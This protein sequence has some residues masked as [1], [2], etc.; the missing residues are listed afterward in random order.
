MN[1]QFIR[2]SS[3]LDKWE[4]A[5]KENK[6]V[7]VMMDANLDHLTWGQTN[8]LSASHSSIKLKSLIDLLFEK[9][10]PLGFSQMVKCATRFERGQPMSG[11][12]HLYTNKPEKL[13]S[14]QTYFTGL[15]DHKLLKVTRFS[16]SFRQLPR[17]VRKRMFKNFNKDEFMKMLGESRFEDILY[18]YDVDYAANMLTSKIT[19]ILDILAPVKTIQVKSY[20]VPGLSQETKDLQRERNFA[21]KM[22]TL[23][24]HPYDW[25]HFRSLRNR[26]TASLR[27]DKV[28]CD[29]Y[30][31]GI[32]LSHYQK[33]QNVTKCYHRATG[34]LRSYR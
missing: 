21:Q 7:I 10:I 4:F 14:V 22:A 31:S 6:E 12:D 20:Y 15:S 17:Y 26:A 25:R 11:L 32:K 23:T 9:I 30:G 24:S 18:C 16:K 1:E 33:V 29:K 3:F 19:T 2:W 13:S 28:K 27:K 8:N 5:L 34:Q